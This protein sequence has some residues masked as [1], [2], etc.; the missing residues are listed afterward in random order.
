MS[1][2]AQA[3]AELL[4]QG[5]YREA[6]EELG[7]VF[8]ARTRELGPKHKDTV[9]VQREL[10]A[11]EREL[12]AFAEARRLL[13]AALAAAPAEAGADS[14]EAAAVLLELGELERAEEHFEAARQRF[15]QAQAIL[16][17]GGR[18]ERDARTAAA[19]AGL[20]ATLWALGRY[21]EAEPLF[22]RALAIRTELLG[23]EHADLAASLNAMA[24]LRWA[25]GNLAA[26]R[27]LYQRAADMRERTLAPRHPKVAESLN[28]LALVLKAQGDPDAARKLHERALEIQRERLGEA[29]PDVAKTLVKM[30]AL[31]KSLGNYAAAQPLA[32][33]AL[34]IR[35]AAYGADHLG[36]ADVLDE[37]GTMLE[38][39]GDYQQA[40]SALKE[41]LE[42]R[43]HRLGEA[44]PKV[45][46]TMSYLAGVYQARG[47]TATARPLFEQALAIDE[48]AFG[49]D[50]P[51]VGLDLVNLARL[52][53]DA[54]ELAAACALYERALPSW[55]KRLGKEHPDVARLLAG[56]AAA[57]VGLGKLE[58]ARGRYLTALGYLEKAVGSA[59]PDVARLLDDLAVA[60]WRGGD[61]GTAAPRLRKASEIV[62]GHL[63]K[64]VPLLSFA[65]QRLF[66]DATVPRQVGLLLSALGAAEDPAATYGLLFSWK[67]LLIE[68]L[69]RETALGRLA[70]D[71]AAAADVHALRAAR[72]A[73]S[74]HYRRLGELSLDAWRRQYEKLTQ[75]KEARE[76]A[77]ARKAP[78][79]GVVADAVSAGDVAG[80]Q[81]ALRE[82]EA[83]V[84]LYRHDR[85]VDGARSQAEYAAFLVMRGDSPRF[86]RLG[87]AA[88]IETAIGAWLAAV[89]SA[90][91]A[92][93][94]WR[95]LEGRLWAP[96]VKLFPARI[97]RVWVS[98]DA[99]LARLPWQLFEADGGGQAGPRLTL[100]TN[101]AREL[102]MIRARGGE[103][104]GPTGAGAVAL[105]VGG[106]DFGG[107]ADEAAGAVGAAGSEAPFAPLPATAEEARAVGE[108]ATRRGISARLLTGAE[109]DKR[110]VVA[111]LQAAQYAHLA[112]HGFFSLETTTA[113]ASTR[114]V[115]ALMAAGES[116]PPGAA[117]RNPLLES[118]LALA[119]AN[120]FA[121]SDGVLL[122]EEI[123]GL[124]LSGLR[125]ITLSACETG[126]GT[127]ATG[128]GVLG[129]RA[130]LAAAGARSIVISLWKVPDEATRRMMVSFYESF[131]DR[132]MPAASAL[133]AAQRRL[134]DEAS[135]QYAAPVNWAGWI[136]VGE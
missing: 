57:E 16:A 22:E 118:G 49:K 109:A 123:V 135:G 80:L 48:E 136:V 58:Q 11:V 15:Q 21:A 61:L 93:P 41:S 26:A 119:A 129:F 9:A 130:A 106:I 94:L 101:S 8:A 51:R 10:G 54:N 75:E 1:T 95:D 134:R 100:Q 108:I 79:A 14:P 69:R 63:E 131:W 24:G 91:G 89:S 76:R 128:Q 88:E 117:D 105:V 116:R 73:L 82:D 42:I 28:N 31:E 85:W 29:H 98:P 66:I 121:R 127:Q 3:A 102:A 65:E 124:D 81:S 25:Q 44:H 23:P 132:G 99:E 46:T 114:G 74:A 67:G 86:V 103:A 122:A 115:L 56:L 35:R 12:G 104:T 71:P 77:V 18:G 120:S 7:R 45:A 40:E 60:E 64:I 43:R 78:A 38:A 72:A 50:H 27:E 96:I 55:E 47:E 125:L 34:E 83:L 2:S 113:A 84:D 97:R 32:E 37:L 133:V 33:R 17:S 53:A 62:A 19:A 111:E 4:K 126:R 39:R 68:A 90:P 92:E 87:P 5:R 70:A 13:E 52:L 36:V 20:A 110:T 112:T 6:R 59:H 30:T 107:R